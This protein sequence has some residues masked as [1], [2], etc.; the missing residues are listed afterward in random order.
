MTQLKHKKER[1]TKHAFPNT[2]LILL[3]APDPIVKYSAEI[4]LA[5]KQK[6]LRV[7]VVKRILNN[8]VIYNLLKCRCNKS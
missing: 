7:I 8:W 1:T 3:E 5:V 6:E 4:E 2:K